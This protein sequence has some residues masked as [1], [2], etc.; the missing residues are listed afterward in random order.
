MR[1]EG[2]I[3]IRRPVEEVFDFVADERNEPQYNRRMTKAEKITPGPVGVGT[4]FR[5]V[6]TGVGRAAEMTIDFTGYEQPRRLVSATHLS[7][8]DI[9]GTLLSEPLPEGTRMRWVWNL[10]PHG[11]YRFLGP[12]VRWMGERQERAIWTGLKQLL[13][14]RPQP[15]PAGA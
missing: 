13:E 15:S 7:N 2:E 14:A 1:V 12:L 5:S 10:E 4:R 11:F 8:M 3:L 6:M 9:K